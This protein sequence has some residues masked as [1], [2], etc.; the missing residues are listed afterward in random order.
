MKVTFSEYR[1]LLRK[2]REGRLSEEETRR[3]DYIRAEIWERFES[4]LMKIQQEKRK[5]SS[6]GVADS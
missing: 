3:L 6:N 5:E 4:L 1:R 2:H